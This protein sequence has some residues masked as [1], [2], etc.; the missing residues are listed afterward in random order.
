M[1]ISSLILPPWAKVALRLAPWVAVAVLIGLLLL[2]RARSE[3]ALAKAATTIE[4]LNGVVA[5]QTLAVDLLNRQ[6]VEAV[7]TREA[8]QSAQR[9]REAAQAGVIDRLSRYQRPQDGTSCPNEAG[10]ALAAEMWGRL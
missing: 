6:Q 8:A 2:A 5:A 3:A 10:D 7:K 1:K 9:Q 4:R